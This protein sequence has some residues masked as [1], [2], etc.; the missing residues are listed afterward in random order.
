MEAD[1]QR[2]VRYQLWR[3]ARRNPPLYRIPAATGT[4]AARTVGPRTSPIARHATG[5]FA[6]IVIV[7]G[8]SIHRQTP[9]RRR[10][11]SFGHWLSR[12]APLV[13]RVV[14]RFV[15]AMSGAW[16]A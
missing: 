2:A 16:F 12:R 15:H 6:R 11:L 14:A 4:H 5:R 13:A 7:S 3:G 10:P 9:R 1:R 8:A